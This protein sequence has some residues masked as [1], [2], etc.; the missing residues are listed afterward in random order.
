MIYYIIIF[1]LFVFLLN[2]FFKYKKTK[3]LLEN[4]YNPL[5]RGYYKCQFSAK[6]DNTPFETTVFVNEIERYKSGESKIELSEIEYG[7]SEL[8]VTHSKIDDHIKSGFKSIVKTSDIDW[9]E[10]EDDLLQERKNKILKLIK[11]IKNK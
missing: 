11:N 8:I 3:K 10:L 6:I 4:I 5:R 2:Y 9:L 7:V 1:I